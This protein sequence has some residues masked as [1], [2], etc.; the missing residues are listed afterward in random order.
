MAFSKYQYEIN[1]HVFVILDFYLVLHGSLLRRRDTKWSGSQCKTSKR[2][3][4]W[5]EQGRLLKWEPV[6]CV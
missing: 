4:K 3:I 1:G 2:A 6:N 5:R